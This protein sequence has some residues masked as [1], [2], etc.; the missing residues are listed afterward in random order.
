M[1]KYIERIEITG[2]TSS[3]S[4]DPDVGTWNLVDISE[5]VE[6][7]QG[8]TGV[9]IEAINDQ[10]SSGRMSSRVVGTSRLIFDR[11]AVRT[12]TGG[13]V[14]LNDNNQIEIFR[15]SSG[16]GFFIKGFTDHRYNFFEDFDNLPVLSATGG[17]SS[18]SYERDVPSEVPPEAIA[19]IGGFGSFEDHNFDPPIRLPRYNAQTNT[20]RIMPI[21]DGKVY[22]HS[23]SDT[24]VFGYVTGGVDYIYEDVTD[25]ITPEVWE[26]VTTPYPSTTLAI[27][28]STGGLGAGYYLRA[29]GEDFDRSTGCAHSS[30]GSYIDFVKTDEN[31]EFEIKRHA[32]L[33]DRELVTIFVAYDDFQE[34]S[35]TEVNLDQP[36]YKPGDTITGSYDGFAPVGNATLTDDY[37]NEITDS[38]TIDSENKTFSGPTLFQSPSVG[39][40]TPGLTPTKIK[41]KLE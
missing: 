18:N 13:I 35:P 26:R 21:T 5:F 36:E 1:L 40:Q 3:G 22:G 32:D 41:F 9:I 19:L 4:N 29:V 10:N 24:A 16:S 11:S 14:P 8:A 23:F 39:N 12:R 37:D 33:G 6:V 20:H 7:P 27:S 28:S 31:G 17:A 2:L 30:S 25:P 34:A 38:V 15:E